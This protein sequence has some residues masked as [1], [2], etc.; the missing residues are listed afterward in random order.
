M[1]A[2]KALLI[3][4]NVIDNSIKYRLS[5][6]VSAFEPPYIAYSERNIRIVTILGNNHERCLN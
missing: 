6:G 1:C 4:H 5:T 2:P 3:I